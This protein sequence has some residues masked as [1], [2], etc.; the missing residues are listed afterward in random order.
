MIDLVDVFIT[1]IQKSSNNVKIAVTRDESA[2]EFII[3]NY[4]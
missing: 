2:K 4:E 3:S 1:K